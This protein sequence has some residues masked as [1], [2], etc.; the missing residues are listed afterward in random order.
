T[1]AGGE[2][3][4]LLV[5]ARPWHPGYQATCD[6][7][8]VAVEKCDLILPA[9]RGPAGAPHRVVLGDRPNSVVRGCWSTGMTGLVT[10]LV[11]VTALVQRLLQTAPVPPSRGN[12]YVAQSQGDGT[13]AAKEVT[14]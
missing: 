5:F 1:P 10:V 4:V 7:T 6:G 12:P 11:L 2:G 14:T 8:P 9:V 3:K 13:C